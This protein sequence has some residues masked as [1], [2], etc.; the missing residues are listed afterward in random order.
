MYNHN[1]DVSALRRICDFVQMDA[2]TP[3]GQAFL[4]DPRN[5]KNVVGFRR[6]QGAALKP[7]TYA[8]CSSQAGMPDLRVLRK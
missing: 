4:P 2:H 3:V 5:Q 7:H 8:P 1:V 6:D